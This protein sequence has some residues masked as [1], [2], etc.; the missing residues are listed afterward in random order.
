MKVHHTLEDIGRH[1]GIK[2]PTA[3]KMLEALRNKGYLI[4]GR[5]KATG[6]SIHLIERAGSAEIV[7]EIVLAGMN[8]PHYC[9]PG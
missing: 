7:T 1:Y 4:F 3:H 8:E 9:F 2:A 5:D 6:F